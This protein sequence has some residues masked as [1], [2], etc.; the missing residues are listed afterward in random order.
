MLSSR[1]HD[2]VNIGGRGHATKTPGRAGAHLRKE[3]P[4]G[5]GG[6]QTTL[7]GKGQER[8]SKNVLDAPGYNE[9]GQLEP[10][11]LFKGGK[12]DAQQT[13]SISRAFAL[14]DKTNKTPHPKSRKA[15]SIM[16]P[17]AGSAQKPAAKPLFTSAAPQVTEE[18]PQAN[19]RRPSAGRLSIRAPNSVLRDFKTPDPRGRRAHWDIGDMDPDMEMDGNADTSNSV[20][21]G[22]NELENEENEL[23]Y[24]PPSAIV[25]EYRPAFDMPDM[26]AFG[27]AVRALTYSH[28]PRDEIDVLSTIR[29]EEVVDKVINDPSFYDLSMLDPPEDDPFPPRKTALKSIDTRGRSATVVSGKGPKSAPHTR[30]VS[31]AAVRS[32]SSTGARKPTTRPVS[33]ASNRPVSVAN[34]RPPSAIPPAQSRATS[35]ATKQLPRRPGTAPGIRPGETTARVAGKMMVPKTAQVKVAQRQPIETYIV[36]GLDVSVNQLALGD[37]FVLEL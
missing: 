31:V 29:D 13:Q 16:T 30:P 18:A 26:Q 17:V 32:V 7:T 35:G 11:R 28:W 20:K 5:R 8:I 14:L 9:G 34:I 36:E 15:V 27:K 19:V 6:A 3:N 24:M 10:K 21:I 1:F 2:D 37:D 33:V 12:V 23:E 22:S 25:E 4:G